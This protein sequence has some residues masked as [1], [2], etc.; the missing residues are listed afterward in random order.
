MKHLLLWTACAFLFFTSG[1]ENQKP[2]STEAPVA[3]DIEPI[4][5]EAVS[6]VQSGKIAEGTRLMNDAVD[7]IGKAAGTDHPAYAKALFRQATFHLTLDDMESAAEI[8]G[9]AAAIEG[10]DHQSRRDQLTYGMNQAEILQFLGKDAEALAVIRTNVSQRAEF[11]GK[12]HS[13][14]SYGLAEL[15]SALIRAGKSDEALSV[16]E[17][18]VDIDMKNGNPHATFGV[19]YQGIAA[20]QAGKPDLA[21]AHWKELGPELRTSM[22]RDFEIRATKF[23]PGV[24]IAPLEKFSEIIAEHPTPQPEDKETILAMLSNMA[25]QTGDHSSRIRALEKIANLTK[26]KDDAKYPNALRALAIAHSEAGNRAKEEKLH[27]EAIAFCK[28]K[29]LQNELVACLRERAISADRIGDATSAATF[30]RQSVAAARESNDKLTLGKSLAAQG[31][32]LHHQAKPN[33]AVPFLEESLQLL[34]ENDRY[35]YFVLNHVDLAREGKACRCNEQGPLTIAKM[36]K[37]AMVKEMG[38]GIV[39]DVVYSPEDPEDP[40][41]IEVARELTPEE[42]RKLFDA[43]T[44]VYAAIRRQLE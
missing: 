14:Y 44:N 1:C 27:E 22:V 21:F 3:E 35:R 6:L 10:T 9:Q 43:W 31:I 15:A 2:E 12:D 39:K 19:L 38:E 26:G 40:Y 42:Q 17:E 18:C 23:A 13:G 7:R 34:P 16:S 11:Y 20:C 37:D 41:S 8:C 30:H 4:F 36:L 25:R 5:K 24:L 32:F 28:E 29:N 33:E